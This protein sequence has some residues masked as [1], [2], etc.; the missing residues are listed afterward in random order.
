L[1]VAFLSRMTSVPLALAGFVAL[2]L[3][4]PLLAVSG[5]ALVAELARGEKGEALGLFNASSSLAGAVGAFLGGWMMT[6]AGYGMVCVAAA[7]MVA[8]AVL[9]AG[10]GSR[11]HAESPSAG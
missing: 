1:A 4:W 8:L 3:A 6:A 11:R 5:T 9:G 2:V 10:G 7:V